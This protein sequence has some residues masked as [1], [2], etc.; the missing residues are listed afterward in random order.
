MKITL[1]KEL[2]PN[3]LLAKGTSTPVKKNTLLAFVIYVNNS[4]ISSKKSYFFFEKNILF[5]FYN[6]KTFF[7]QYMLKKYLY[8]KL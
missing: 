4:I 8:A 6:I 5:V 1:S 2:L 7:F 3:K